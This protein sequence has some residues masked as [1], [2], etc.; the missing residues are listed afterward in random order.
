MHKSWG[1]GIGGA[2]S[3]AAVNIRVDAPRQAATTVEQTTVFM[4]FV[5]M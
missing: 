5:N 4:R 1:A 3:A 2:A